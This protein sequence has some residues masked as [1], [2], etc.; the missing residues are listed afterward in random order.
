MEK[1]V[2]ATRRIQLELWQSEYRK[3]EL[4]KHQTDM[5][6]ELQQFTTKGDKIL[7]VPLA[8]IGRK[9][10]FTKELEVAMLEGSAH[11]AVHSL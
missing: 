5:E 10:L 6:V 4:L 1:R 7:D 11:V 3:A 2:I 8:K 9:G